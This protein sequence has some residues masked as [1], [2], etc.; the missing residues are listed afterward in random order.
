MASNRLLTSSDLNKMAFNSLFLQASF[1]YERMQACG[2]AWSI[3][4]GLQKVYKGNPEK[5]KDALRRHMEFFNVHP[6]LVTP[7]MGIVIAMEEKNEDPELIRAVKVAT[8]GPLGGIGD[9]I[10]WF[11]LLPIAA[12]L[13][14]GFGLDGNPLGPII[15]LVMFNVVHLWIRFGFMHYFYNFGLGAFES[16]KSI[17]AHFQKA[18]SIIGVTVVGALIASFVRLSVALKFNVGSGANLKEVNVQTDIVDAVM[19]NLLPLCFTLGIYYLIAKKNWSPTRVIFGI[20][21][22][23]VAMSFLGIL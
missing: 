19:P 6:F 13:G 15:F 2:W 22:F 4:P 8:M 17:T 12:S 5:M 21:I 14:A 20:I 3:L 10:F 7:I 16:L 1:N 23:G 18:A 11:T 9:A